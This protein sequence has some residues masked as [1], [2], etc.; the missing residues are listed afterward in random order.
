[1]Y[2]LFPI[3]Y[4]PYANKGEEEAKEGQVVNFEEVLKGQFSRLAKGKAFHRAF[5]PLD[6]FPARLDHGIQFIVIPAVIV[7]EES[8]P[9]YA[10][11]KC[12][13]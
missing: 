5:L 12:Q 8:K 1:M 11:C 6:E 4:S 3:I 9:L 2:L 13:V 7:M 10:G